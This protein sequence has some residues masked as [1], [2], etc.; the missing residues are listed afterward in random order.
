VKKTY[1]IGEEFGAIALVIVLS[2]AGGAILGMLNGYTFPNIW[3]FKGYVL[4]PILKK[5][6]I[7][8]IIMMIIMGCVVRNFFGDV[9]LPYNNAWAQWVRTCCLAI[10]LVRGGMN[11]SFTG[12]GI[13]VLVMTF[14][15]LMFEAT[16]A[17]LIALG[18]FNMPIEVAY[19]L[20]FA[21]ASVA[22]AIVVPQLMRWNELGYGRSKGIAG[23]LI[24]S[25]TF[26]NIVCLILFGV[27]KTI[28]F[29][30]AA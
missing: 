2:A 3:P 30:Y 18:L 6:H 16:S 1:T 27:C 14:V 4:K 24:A 12:K 19:S 7:P 26:D 8:P 15:P 17:A 25:C 28:A 29:E 13:L 20:G 9:V 10:L 11:V 22:P 21:V 23:S 5:I